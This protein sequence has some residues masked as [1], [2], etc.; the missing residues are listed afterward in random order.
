MGTHSTTA[1]DSVS[2]SCIDTATD[3]LFA[4]HPGSN[5]T[6]GTAGSYATAGAHSVL[7]SRVVERA[8]GENP[9]AHSNEELS[10]ALSSLKEITARINEKPTWFDSTTPL[11][12][13][14]LELP[15]VVEI[16]G[17]LKKA[18]G[19]QPYSH[20]RETVLTR[21]AGSISLSFFPG[22][23]PDHLK[24]E[25]LHVFQHLDCSDVLSRTLAFA[26]LYNLC[27]SNTSVFSIT[28]QRC[29]LNAR[30][31]RGGGAA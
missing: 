2:G 4:E 17:L 3:L 22:I 7:A 26:F 9:S 27:V 25:S 14:P 12:L 11:N 21:K 28:A 18:D 30:P 31:E 15:T 13:E 20:L 6:T 19:S 1:S 24:A 8:V 16:Q 5:G 29:S 23:D 10:T